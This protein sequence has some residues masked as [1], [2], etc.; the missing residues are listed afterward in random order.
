MHYSNNWIL[1]QGLRVYLVYRVVHY[2]RKSYSNKVF[3][4][5]LT[6]AVQIEF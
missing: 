6:N 1:L 5:N 3:S 4:Y 2:R